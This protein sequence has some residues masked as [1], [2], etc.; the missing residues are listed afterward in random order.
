MSGGLREGERVQRGS[1]FR[2]GFEGGMQIWGQ[3]EPETLRK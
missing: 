1:I 3:V 2:S